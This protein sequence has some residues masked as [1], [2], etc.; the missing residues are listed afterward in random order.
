MACPV[1]KLGRIQFPW[2]EYHIFISIITV[3]LVAILIFTRLQEG[4]P[5]SSTAEFRSHFQA[6]VINYDW[7][8]ILNVL[9]PAI[10]VAVGD[11]MYT[12]IIREYQAR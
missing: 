3:S 9:V 5:R 12:L 8:R 11:G 4:A 10:I 1:I 6:L 2:D 7:G